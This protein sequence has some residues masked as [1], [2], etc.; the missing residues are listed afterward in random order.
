MFI[1]E[2][3]KNNPRDVCVKCSLANVVKTFETNI[4]IDL[5]IVLQNLPKKSSPFFRCLIHGKDKQ[6]ETVF[7][8]EISAG[9]GRKCAWHD[10][11]VRSF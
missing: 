1:E 4:V 6:E 11:F 3:A 8:V 5:V 7:D 2:S 10:R 9:R